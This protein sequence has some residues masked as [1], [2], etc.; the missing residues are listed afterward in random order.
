MEDVYEEE[1]LSLRVNIRQTGLFNIVMAT[2]LEGKLLIVTS[3]TI[4]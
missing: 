4:K 3:F 2:D 1:W